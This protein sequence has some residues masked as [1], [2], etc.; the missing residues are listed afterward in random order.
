M[1]WGTSAK[2]RAVRSLLL[3]CA[4]GGLLLPACAIGGHA[5]RPVAGLEVHTPPTSPS[6]AAAAAPATAPPRPLAQPLNDAARPS[7]P[8]SA[9]SPPHPL[10]KPLSEPNRVAPAAPPRASAAPP[11]NP[12]GPV[13]WQGDFPDPFV[14]PVSDPVGTGSVYY[15]YATQSGT[16]QVQTLRSPDLA[17]WEWVGEALP[18]LA[19]WATF[20]YLWGP[21][22]LAR[23]TGYVLYYAT[24][25][26]ATA[27]QCI[28]AAV[29][30]LP[31]GPFLDSS[32]HPFICQRERGGS[33][34]PSPFVDDDGTPWL[35]WKSEGTLSGEPTRIWAQRLTADGQGLLGQP[36]ELVHTDQPWELPI[37]EGPSMTRAGGRYLLAY[38][39]NRWETPGYAIGYAV[40]ATPAGPCRKP[41]GA[42]VMA[43]NASEAG[44]GSPSFFVDR[45]GA[46][47]M[48]YHAWTAGQVGY[49]GGAR[50]LHVA[51]VS[52]AGDLMNVR[53]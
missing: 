37:V 48:A 38:A 49:P 12:A 34:D 20:G 52:L 23:R 46:L 26:T 2:P 47:R 9:P 1:G 25:E 6:T 3:A 39:G 19:S 45:A 31:Q 24:R 40:C 30:L 33:I 50:R 51:S 28:S 15:A 43:S 5:T 17:H 11:A 10:P 16:T 18:R 7:G 42:P 8:S 22:V 35:V 21:S 29:S 4:A 44:P 32:N 13:L 53:E 41:L 36:S 14:A 27:R